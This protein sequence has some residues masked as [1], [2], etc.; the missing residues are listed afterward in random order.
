MICKNTVARKLVL[1]TIALFLFAPFSFFSAQT[2]NVAPKAVIAPVKKIHRVVKS[3]PDD[4]N[5]TAEKSIAVDSKVIV[6]LRVCEGKI[7][8]N[9]W[10]RNEIRAFVSGG[11]GV[12]FRVQQKGGQNGTP[13]WVKVL[14]FDPTKN[15]DVETDECLSG[16]EIE[17]DVPRGA[18]VDVKSNP[19]ET[20]IDSVRK[21]TVDNVGGDIYLNHI[22]QG[23]YAKTND[24][25]VTAENSSGAMTLLSTTGNIVAFGVSPDEI[26]DVFKAKTS[27][28][29]IVLQKIG[30]RQT[31]VGS[32]SG[33]IKFI[34]AFQNGGQYILGTQN[35]SI[36]LSI[37][38][39][40]S[41]KLNASFGFGAFNSE[42]PL[43]NLVKTNDSRA[44]S[45]SASLGKAEAVLILRTSS[46][47][48]RIKKQ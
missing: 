4:G 44:Q 40:S 19:T 18:T 11:S 10:E 38:E 8:I 16:D 9:G 47:S 33:S 35:G 39:K 22:A 17:L 15:K 20:T 23:V 3:V 41:F 26:G 25:N 45:L 30:Y 28:G 7:K 12:G 21:V 48:I 31:E 34:G 46:G 2:V 13:V 24:G 14:G 1:S 29:A 37:P 42:I 36:L 32:N 43:E 5:A 27:S 6:S